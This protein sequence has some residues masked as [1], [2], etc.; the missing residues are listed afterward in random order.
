[1]GAL[2]EKVARLPRGVLPLLAV[3]GLFLFDR[4]VAGLDNAYLTQ[5]FVLVGIN[6]I[7]AVSL[8]LINGF[9][10]QLSIGHAGFMAIGAYV[11]AA[12]SVY[13]GAEIQAFFVES[14]G[15]PMVLARAAFFCI[16]VATGGLSA[17]LAGILVGIPT[18]RLRGDYLAIATL[19]FGEII[20]II[21]LNIDAVG[22]ARGFSVVPSDYDYDVRFEGIFEVYAMVL[23]TIVAVAHLAYSIR[24]RAYIA[25]KNDEIATESLGISATRVKIEAFVVAAFFG[26]VAGVLFSQSQGYVHTNSFTFLRSVEAL[27][28]VVLGGMG[29]ITGS[30]VAAI[31]LTIVP[32]LFR[33]F[34]EYRMVSYALVLIAMMVWR[35]QGLFGRSEITLDRIGRWL[36]SAKKEEAA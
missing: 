30:V 6:I 24:G 32:E 12:V 10:G 17:A 28:F 26:G 9:T 25:V 7:L 1:M 18:L 15:L 31:V 13:F 5:V 29:S 22:G 4:A 16:V 27:V 19:G 34:S 23:L 33:A 36:P 8:N 14:I 2:S 21:I 20:R 11:A 3:A 35:P